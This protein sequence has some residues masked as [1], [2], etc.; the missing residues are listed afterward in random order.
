MEPLIYYPTFEPPSDIWLKF[1]LLY[2]ESFRPI[3]PENKRH[4]ISHGFRIIENETDLVTLYSPSYN[5][6]LEAS[7]Q[8]I[9]EVEKILVDPYRRSHLFDQVNVL[10]RW[11]DPQNWIF[12]VH[13]E[14]FSDNWADFCEHNNL[15]LRTDDGIYMSEE[16]A[17]LFM[18]Y[19]AKEIAFRE[20]AAVI[21][22][23]NRF[24]NFTNHARSTTPSI[25]RKTRFAK[26]LFNFLV[27]RNLS[28]IPFERLIDF[29]NNNRHR[30]TAFHRELDNVQAKIGEGY[31]NQDFID[32]YNNIYSEFSGEILLQG[33][34]IASIPFATYMS[35]QNPDAT[36]P[37]Y[38]KEILGGL[39]I[40]LGGGYSLN[41]VLKDT[42]TRRYCK[43][44]LLNLERL[45]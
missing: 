14:K 10:R 2:F 37:E 8:S 40:V 28:E 9:E 17:F 24:D 34:G 3:V 26:G 1:S 45:R 25:N 42:Q 5:D 7:L 12:F 18:T 41:R 4:L 30:L 6:G 31:S 32:S 35:I 44:Y 23:N 43:K 11:Q 38:V 29:R 19:L 39:G 22:D 21:T 27:P 13:R 33:L 15:G 20:S 36:S 16:L